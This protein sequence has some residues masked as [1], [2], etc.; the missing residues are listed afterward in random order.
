MDTF[1]ESWNT[2][3]PAAGIGKLFIFQSYFFFL[4]DED[5][6]YIISKLGIYICEKEKTCKMEKKVIFLDK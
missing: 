3:I 5:K 6:D 2:L 4:V 1:M